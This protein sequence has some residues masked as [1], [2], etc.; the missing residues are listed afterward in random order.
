MPNRKES[1]PSARD[2]NLAALQARIDERLR[3]AAAKKREE[4][5]KDDPFDLWPTGAFLG[6]LIE[7]MKETVGSFGKFAF[8]G[9]RLLMAGADHKTMESAP[10]GVLLSCVVPRGNVAD[11]GAQVA[12]WRFFGVYTGKHEDGGIHRHGLTIVSAG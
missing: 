9:F 1:L 12:G 4:T 10:D 3:A 2:L 11:F 8:I 5:R 7:P 6:E